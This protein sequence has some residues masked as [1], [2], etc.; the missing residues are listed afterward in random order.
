MH[1]LVRIKPLT[2]VK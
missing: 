1:I 2:N